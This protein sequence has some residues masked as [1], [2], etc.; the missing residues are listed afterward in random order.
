M[1]LKTLELVRKS[2]PTSFQRPEGKVKAEK[3]GGE[4]EKTNGK[5]IKG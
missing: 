4:K 5:T 1:K 2:Q 3:E